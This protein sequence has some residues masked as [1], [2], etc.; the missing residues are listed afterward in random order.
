MNDDNIDP[1]LDTVNEL[2]FLISHRIRRPIVTASGLFRL[3]ISDNATPEDKKKAFEYLSQ[4]IKEMDECTEEL[5][6]ALEKIRKALCN[7]EE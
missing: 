7:P 1:F 2:M 4:T 5:I 6:Q 3:L